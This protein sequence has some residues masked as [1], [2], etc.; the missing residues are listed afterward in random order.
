[1]TPSSETKLNTITFLIGTT[2]FSHQ[3]AQSFRRLAAPQLIGS[4][5]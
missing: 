2:P 5:P 3:T 4:H 1:M